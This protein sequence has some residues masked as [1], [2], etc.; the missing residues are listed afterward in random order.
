MQ[1]WFRHNIRFALPVMN[2]NGDVWDYNVYQAILVIW[3][4]MDGKVYLYGIQN[5]KR[6]RDT[7]LGLNIQM[8]RNPLPVFD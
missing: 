2:E 6:N 8:V 4:A 1:V 3:Y 7:H 5:V